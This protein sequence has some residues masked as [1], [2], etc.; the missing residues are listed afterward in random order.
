MGGFQGNVTVATKE[1]GTLA[2]GGVPFGATNVPYSLAGTYNNGPISA[3]LGYERNAVGDK[4]AQIAGSYNVGVAN[5]MASYAQTK[6]GTTGLS[7]DHANAFTPATATTGASGIAVAPNAKKPK[8]GWSAR[9]SLPAQAMSWSA[10]VR[11]RV[12]PA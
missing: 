11:R 10:T 8:L 4:Y 1:T 12:I 6:F 2:V 9:T 7:F 5:L 3:M